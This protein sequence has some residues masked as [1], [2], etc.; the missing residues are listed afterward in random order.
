M[1]RAGLR[2]KPSPRPDRGSSIGAR[3]SQTAAKALAGIAAT[4]VEMLRIVREA[5]VIPAQAWLALAEVAGAAVLAIWSPIMRAALAAYVQ[6]LAVLRW[7][8]E[9]VRPAYGVVAVCVAAAVALVVSQFMHYRGVSVG[10][11]SY[12]GVEAVAPAPEVG[13]ER[14]GAAHGW[15]PIPIALAALVVTVVAMRGRWRA[16]RLLAPLGVA[17]L[18]ISLAVD[19]PKG[20]D[21]GAAAA[22]Y[23]GVEAVL[24]EG[25]W[26]QL[27]AGAVLACCGFLLAAHLR[28]RQASAAF[29][30]AVGSSPVGQP[31]IETQRT[32]P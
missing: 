11:P 19:A 5:L 26:T 25:F 28:P 27:V 10:A 3:I 32:R 6:A 23:Q 4:L 8:Q 12:A 21:A 30:P 1:G 15:A 2:R 14:A 22:A 31:P 20:L 13:R 16:A 24:L 18:V 7:A 29:R 9:R 17:V